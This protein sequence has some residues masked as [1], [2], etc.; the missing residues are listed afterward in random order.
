MDPSAMDAAVASGAPR[1]VVKRP[2]L[3]PTLSTMRAA[4]PGMRLEGRSSRFDV[5]FPAG[6]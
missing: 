6:G 1:I 3:A 2:R 5:Y 4:A